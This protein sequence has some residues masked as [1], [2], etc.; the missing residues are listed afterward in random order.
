MTSPARRMTGPVATWALL[1]ALTL[2]SYLAWTDAA[3]LAR[4]IAGAAAI[5]IAMCK[6]WLIGMR[7][8]ELSHAPLALRLAYGAWVGVVGVSLL[9]MFGLA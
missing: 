5:V 9:V 6:A 2:L 7:Y 3:L 1:V 8:M 4:G